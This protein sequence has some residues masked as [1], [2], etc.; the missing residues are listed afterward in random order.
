MP[1]LGISKPAF[2]V[3]EIN[4]VDCLKQ[5]NLIISSTFLQQ[6]LNLIALFTPVL[7]VSEKCYND[8]VEYVLA[9]NNASMWAIMSK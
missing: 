4:W 3:T 9:L 1:E 7:G 8:S 2:G 6:D 5:H